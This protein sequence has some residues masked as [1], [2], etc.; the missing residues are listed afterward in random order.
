MK[1]LLILV[2]HMH[3]ALNTPNTVRVLEFVRF[4]ASAGNPIP[5]QIS[6]PVDDYGT[7]ARCLRL[8]ADAASAM[9]EDAIPAIQARQLAALAQS[10]FEK[11]NP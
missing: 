3:A 10:I 9:T 11:G 6:M 2:E 4:H 1:R 5:P 7:V 8:I